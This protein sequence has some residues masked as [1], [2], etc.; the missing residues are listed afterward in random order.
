M[1]EDDVEMKVRLAS[2]KV[3][4]VSVLNA[5]SAR[6]NATISSSLLQKP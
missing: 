4:L 2:S 5:M 6:S 1:S 3:I